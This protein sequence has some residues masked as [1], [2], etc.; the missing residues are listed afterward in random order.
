MNEL[1]KNVINEVETVINSEYKSSYIEASTGVKRQVIDKY[2]NGLS[3]VENMKLE[4]AEQILSFWD[5][6]QVIQLNKSNWKNRAWFVN[7]LEEAKKFLS[8][9]VYDYSQKSSAL[10]EFKH[11]MMKKEKERL[12]ELT[13]I[14][15][16]TGGNP[17][18]VLPWLSELSEYDI[19]DK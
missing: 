1:V 5:N 9:N 10:N 8:E 3:D 12:E 19:A 11:V 18:E 17:E 13:G 2:R 14:P 7:N 6:K 4:T 15:R 16:T